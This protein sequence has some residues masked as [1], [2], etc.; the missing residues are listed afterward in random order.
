MYGNLLPDVEKKWNP[1]LKV[2]DTVF[3]A[4]EKLFYIKSSDLS[5]V[6]IHVE[7]IGHEYRNLVMAGIRRQLNL[8]FPGQY[9]V[10][11]LDTNQNNPTLRIRE[12]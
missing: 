3:L 6:D 1:V 10:E 2:I 5:H 12:V 11:L 8:M 4:I 7:Y 9:T